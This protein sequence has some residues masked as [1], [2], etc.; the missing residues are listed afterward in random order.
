MS[1]LATATRCCWPTL[2]VDAERRCSA[3]SS[4]NLA[5]EP[6][7]LLGRI[8]VARCAAALLA[9]ED[10]RQQNIVDDRAIR[11]QVEH[12]KDD[13]EMLGAEAVERGAAQVGDRRARNRNRAPLRRDDAAG[14]AQE[15][16][17]SGAGG[18]HNQQAL[19]PP[20]G[21]AFDLQTEGIALP[22]RERDVGEPKDVVVTVCGRRH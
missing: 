19:A 12:L 15:G 9:G 18:S 8:A 21:E 20:H 17:F 2:R 13:A 1:A 14:E 7:R 3:A 4:P 11:Q 16:R 6:P 22:P 5:E 10:Q